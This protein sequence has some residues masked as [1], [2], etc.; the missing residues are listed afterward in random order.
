MMNYQAARTAMVDGQIRPSDVTLYPILEAM[1]T[2]PREVYV[3]S[4]KMPI[5]YMGADMDLG[6]G[7]FVL[8]PRV[9]AKMLEK[10]NI[11][12]ND[13]VLDIGCGMGYSAAVIAHMAE[14]VIAIES[15]GALAA[16]AETV[17]SDQSAFNAVVQS[18]PLADG[19][20][21]HGPYDA[22]II[23]GGVQTV[24]EALLSQLK[25]GGRIAAIFV[26]GP[27]GQCRI[28]VQTQNGVVWRIAFDATAPILAGF[29]TTDT[30]EF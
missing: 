23:E 16:E 19:A 22:I 3:P 20:V 26:E 29:T 14:A 18:S 28:G 5:A 30:F 17:L 24:P 13:L 21:E 12:P 7:R 10:L 11:Q 4:A 27:V 2:I 25:L 15:D 1:L 8:D 9:F 6:G